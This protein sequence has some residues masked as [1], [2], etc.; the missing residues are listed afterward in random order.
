MSISV[1]QPTLTVNPSDTTVPAG[2]SVGLTCTIKIPTTT[3]GQAELVTYKFYVD[4][5]EISSSSSSSYEYN[6]PVS[7][8][9]QTRMFTCTA[10]VSRSQSVHSVSQPLS[11][12][13]K[14][15]H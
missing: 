11:V 4:G 5:V 15:Y 1:R 7:D 2:V 3:G 14:Y 10:G 12:V 8:I 9:G 13:G 6:V